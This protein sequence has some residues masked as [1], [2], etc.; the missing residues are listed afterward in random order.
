MTKEEEE[1]V[2]SDAEHATSSI[3][4]IASV[5]YGSTTYRPRHRRRL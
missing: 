5:K 1:K 2:S 3:A 4:D